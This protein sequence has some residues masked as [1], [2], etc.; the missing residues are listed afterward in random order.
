MQDNVKMSSPKRSRFTQLRGK[1]PD[2]R[3]PATRECIRNY[4]PPAIIILCL[5]ILI[6]FCATFKSTLNSC[7]DL[8]IKSHQHDVLLNSNQINIIIRIDE[9]A[10]TI[11][12]SSIR[13]K[14]SHVKDNYIFAGH[15]R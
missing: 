6:I 7:F 3:D 9:K 11:L 12:I 1:L 10:S 4:L 5:V 15:Q 8:Q 14:N 13:V 2:V